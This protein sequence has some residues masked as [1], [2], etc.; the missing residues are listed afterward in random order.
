MGVIEQDKV[1][2]ATN[3]GH[4]RDTDVEEEKGALKTRQSLITTMD[5]LHIF[6]TLYDS[7]FKTN[8]C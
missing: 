2:F 1:H 8:R 5:V 6:F 7:V 3:Y 4:Q